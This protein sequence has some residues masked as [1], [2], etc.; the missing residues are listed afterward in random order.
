VQ[1]CPGC[2]RENPEEF[3]HCP[4]CGTALAAAP[5][6]ER[7]KLATV[8]FCD[9]AGS[10]ALGERLDPE[11][12][13][14]LMRSYFADAREILERHGGTVEKFIGDAVVAAFG[15]PVAHEDDALRACRAAHDIQASVSSR[16][17]LR[18]G[19]NTGEVVAGD[20]TGREGFMTGD[21]VNVAAR[22]EQGAAPGEVLIGEET[23]RLV[24]DA[25][26]VEPVEPLVVKGKSQALKAYRLLEVGEVVA[27]QESPLVG[28]D[29]ELAVLEREFE[30]VVG[31]QSCRVVTIVGEPGVGKSRLASELAARIGA[32][33]VR[34]GCLSYGEGITYW[35][36][37]Q[38]VR[39][40]EPSPE[41]LA[42]QIAQ[43]LGFAD[44][45]TSAAELA[46][47][48]AQFLAGAA[49]EPLVVLVDDIH[50]AE[51]ALL[52]LLAGL[53]R[54][55]GEAPVLLVCLAR[56]EL[57]ER[58]PDW[59]V[60]QR[61]EP[62]GEAELDALLG[63]LDAPLDMRKRLREASAG[64]PLFAEELVAWTKE[65]A[66]DALPTSLNAL[67]GARLDRLDAGERDA[68]ERG[69][70]E[71]E[72]FHRGAVV[73]LSASDTR[74][75][76][77]GE[78]DALAVRDF[79]RPAQASFAGEAA[80]RF[81][82]ILVREAAYAATAKKLRASLHEQFANWLERLV[83]ERIAEYE[84]I[85]GYHLEQSYRYREELGTLDAGTRETGTRAASH[86]TTAGRRA[87]DRGDV[88]ATSNLLERALELGVRDPVERA[89]VQAIFGQALSRAGRQLESEAVRE[90]CIEDAERVGERALAVR[91][92]VGLA[93]SR[94][95]SD[96]AL[97][98][99]EMQQVAEDAI[100]TLTALG[101]S[102]YLASAQQLLGTALGM[103]GRQRERLAALEQGLQHA[104][105]V[106]DRP[107]MWPVITSLGR[108]LCDGPTPVPDAI[109]RCDDLL[110]GYGADRVA[111]ASVGQFR[112]ALL[113]MAGRRDDAI[114]ALARS[115]A[116]LD[117]LSLSMQMGAYRTYA[118]EVRR[119]A[120][121]TAGAED[122]LMKQWLYFRDRRGG[123]PDR[124]A[125]GSAFRL[126]DLYCDEGRW[127]DA[128]RSFGEA[129]DLPRSGE[130]IPCLG[131]AVEARLEAHRGRF[132]EAVELAERAV[133]SVDGDESPNLCAHMWQTLAEVQRAAD[134]TAEAAAAT[135]KAL[136]L[137]AQ[138]GNV[139][140]AERLRSGAP[141]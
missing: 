93:M 11:A 62:L 138:K 73:E 10:T 81:K 91:V 109:A 116:V 92:R 34:G 19:V 20:A 57:V 39:E 53:P 99:G 131:L 103:M 27:R 136:A 24:R 41:R 104:E 46:R 25:V 66:V 37:A 52:E 87:F 128:E 51:P 69:A 101:A 140:A 77:P 121:D 33:A 65:S 120:G 13:R 14:E 97:S 2:G 15:V 134:H 133:E 44:A 29:E 61:L 17:V 47:A 117:E 16:I 94:G 55:I 115:S 118:V 72:L 98:A 86:L 113:A 84:E 67:L 3:R 4:Y 100:A 5:A 96:P 21:T 89:H 54:A 42:P 129:R 45:T 50:W 123:A 26:A 112:A 36:I 105:A 74:P 12:V 110:E 38:I 59:N 102:A 71:G 56:P 28:R 130:Y 78:L 70:I 32:R 23:Y 9:V 7:R 119:L 60:T 80:F 127:D 137:Y 68:L 6:A 122:E 114:E 31:E 48:I 124:R 40:L 8:L 126:V 108:S 95:M 22:L 88:R 35:P 111:E 18:I 141:T 43:L 75:R 83:G 79:I 106:G 1:I 85:L 135:A 90:A 132:A 125:A 64:I 139:A 63:E 58:E 82:H 76:V 107:A 30:A 49:T